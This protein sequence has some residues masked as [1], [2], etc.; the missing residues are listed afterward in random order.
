MNIFEQI[1]KDIVVDIQKRM[2]STN[3]NY[4]TVARG[5]LR[6]TATL[7]NVEIFAIKRILF[8]EYGRRPNSNPDNWKSLMPFIL[9]WVAKKFNLKKS[10][11]YGLATAISQKIAKQGTQILQDRSKGL[12]L[13]LI[14]SRAVKKYQPLIA[15]EQGKKVVS[16]LVLKWKS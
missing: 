14:K 7:N 10:E 13:S 9:P 6:Y 2:D 16:A 1:G 15:R 11:S 4:T 8:L 12:I 3:R 5:S